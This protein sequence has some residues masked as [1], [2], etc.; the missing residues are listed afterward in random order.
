MCDTVLSESSLV[1]KL[2]NLKKISKIESIENNRAA[3]WGFLYKHHSS[4]TA[5]L[6]CALG[7]AEKPQESHRLAAVP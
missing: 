3:D 7:A 2:L 4:A 1:Y 6:N 5:A